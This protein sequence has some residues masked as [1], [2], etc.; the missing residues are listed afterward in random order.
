MQ[1]ELVF[2]PPSASSTLRS[3]GRAGPKSPSYMK[4]TET[5]TVKDVSFEP[6]K[7]MD[8]LL[9]VINRIIK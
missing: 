9:E 7:L 6:G 5:R 4:T 2:D 3:S 8:L 1:R